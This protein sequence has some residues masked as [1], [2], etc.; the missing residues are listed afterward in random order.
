[1]P[2]FVYMF[3]CLLS[4]TRTLI[5][6]PLALL[7]LIWLSTSPVKL[8][9][10]RTYLLL[11]VFII[12]FNALANIYLLLRLSE[13]I[14]LQSVFMTYEYAFYLFN[15]LM[16]Y[17]DKFYLASEASYLNIFSGLIPNAIRHGLDL[18]QPIDYS[19][20]NDIGITSSRF[21]F[22]GPSQVV[23]LV[24]NFGPFI[25][26]IAAFFAC[27]LLDMV[28][29][30]YY[31]STTTQDLRSSISSVSSIFPLWMIYFILSFRNPLENSVKSA[32]YV[33][34]FFLLL[35]LVSPIVRPKQ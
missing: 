13:T 30:S 15:M 8:T 20:L 9:A 18:V 14:T 5:V 32:L 27:F 34:L 10:L 21:Y 22:G 28:G 7:L 33:F 35:S 19:L 23:E 26:P 31:S 4:G 24:L 29:Q 3:A 1:M 16:A 17:F 2:I 11:S 12:L 6:E 25:A